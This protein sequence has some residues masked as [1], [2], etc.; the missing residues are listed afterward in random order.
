M[1]AAAQ[2]SQDQRN[3][4][5]PA[6]L[7]GCRSASRTRV[8]SPSSDTMKNCA[9]TPSGTD[10]SPSST[11]PGGG[12]DHEAQDRH[13]REASLPRRHRAGGAAEA[14]EKQR[15]GLQDRHQQVLRGGG[16]EEGHAGDAR[17]HTQV[18][19]HHAQLEGPGS[20][21]E[22]IETVLAAA[23]HAADPAPDDGE[24]G[25]QGVASP[26]SDGPTNSMR[27]SSRVLSSPSSARTGQRLLRVRA[28][29]SRALSRALGASSAGGVAGGRRGCSD[30]RASPSVERRSWAGG[31]WRSVAGWVMSLFYTNRTVGWCHRRSQ[32]SPIAV[33]PPSTSSTA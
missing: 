10:P 24:Q 9:A 31:K 22:A 2:A 21:A 17:Q 11:H 33:Q 16:Q 12:G 14:V 28:A 25:E 32:N 15:T 29:P 3:R 30:R 26:S 8:A 23:I 27:G 13:G 20:H 19:A 5:R 4:P 18:D 7:S 1:P 6:A